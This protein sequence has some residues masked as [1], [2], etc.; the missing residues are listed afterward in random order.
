MLAF[1]DP[2]SF[3]LCGVCFSATEQQTAGFNAAVRESADIL[4]LPENRS[5]EIRPANT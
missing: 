4:R 1:N 5:H 2:E 3:D